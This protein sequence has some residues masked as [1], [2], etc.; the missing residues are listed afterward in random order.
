[1]APLRA[2]RTL[3][4]LLP[5]L[6]PSFLLAYHLELE[7][8]PGAVFPYLARFGTVDLHVYAGGVRVDTVWLDGFS[9]NGDTTI[10]VLNPL[11]RMYTEVPITRISSIIGTL[12]TLGPVER[13]AAAALASAAPGRIRGV[14]AT[15]Y[16]LVYGESYIDYWTTTAIPE[17]RQLR[18]IITELVEAISPGT[19]AV[20]KTIPG[21][22]VYVELN[23]RRFQKVALVRLKKLSRTVDDEEKA[24]AVGS[25][26][27]K[28]PLLDALLR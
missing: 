4:V 1:M 13:E 18:R 15:R 21:T 20:S 24:L 17:N 14:P 25:F 16:R 10:T 3:L 7:A 22:P 6:F 9:R 23:F 5:L 26:Y 2:P 12:G 28:A 19:A 8:R 11:G 27:I